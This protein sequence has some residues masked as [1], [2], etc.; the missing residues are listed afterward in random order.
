MMAEM[1]NAEE[2]DLDV[3]KRNVDFVYGVVQLINSSNIDEGIER[4]E[5]LRMIF[6]EAKK[7]FQT[8]KDAFSS[9]DATALKEFYDNFKDVDDFLDGDPERSSNFIYGVLQL[10]SSSGSEMSTMRGECLLAVFFEAERRLEAI[11]DMFQRP[12]AIAQQNS[13]GKFDGLPKG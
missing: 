6:F 8:V 13:C 4:G 1:R 10:A 11:K 7:K 5:C 2:F 3:I 12:V 9:P